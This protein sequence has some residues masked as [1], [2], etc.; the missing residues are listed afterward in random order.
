M[1]CATT[2]AQN[3]GLLPGSGNGTLTERAGEA[4]PTATTLIF[5]H[6]RFRYDTADIARHHDLKMSVSEIGSGNN[7]EL[8]VAYFKIA[9]F[10]TLSENKLG[11]A[12]CCSHCHVQ[13]ACVSQ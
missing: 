2:G 11:G 9:F 13:L 6:A 7:S 3:G 12:N 8:S 4:V 5:D 1:E 10:A